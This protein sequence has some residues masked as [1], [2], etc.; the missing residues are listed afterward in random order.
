MTVENEKGREGGS[1]HP[2][3]STAPVNVASAIEMIRT[4]VDQVLTGSRYSESVES[5]GTGPPMEDIASDYEEAL[6]HILEVLNDFPTTRSITEI[7]VQKGS[8][9]AVL[10]DT[11]V[12]SS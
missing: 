8:H 11:S 7:R 4:I 6:Y 5:A 9:R 2:L 12:D 1:K 3:R 10:L